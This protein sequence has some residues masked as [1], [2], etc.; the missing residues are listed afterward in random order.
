MD[1]CIKECHLTVGS[2]IPTAHCRNIGQRGINMSSLKY[3]QDY[4]KVPAKRGKRVRDEKGR[5]GVITS[6][7][8]PHIMVRIDGTVHSMAYHPQSVTYLE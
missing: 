6:A 3:I 2:S 5:E 4:Y 8:G 1:A 7:H